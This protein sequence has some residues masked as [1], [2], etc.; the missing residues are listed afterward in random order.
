MVRIW[1]VCGDGKLRFQELTIVELT[2]ST[3]EEMYA[4]AECFAL[5]FL[6]ASYMAFVLD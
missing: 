3:R 6:S 5:T 2:R 1:G 4:Y